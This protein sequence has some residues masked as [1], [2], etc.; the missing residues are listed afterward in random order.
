MQFLEG[1]KIKGWIPPEQEMEMEVI[2]T[3]WRSSD[4]S[5]TMSKNIMSGSF[6][7]QSFLSSQYISFSVSTQ[8]KIIF[9]IKYNIFLSLR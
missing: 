3:Q 1:F 8:N 7:A 9:N 5:P 4:D 6:H 2:F